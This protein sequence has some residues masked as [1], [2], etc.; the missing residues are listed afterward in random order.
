MNQPI[1]S[2]KKKSYICQ[3][4][5]V[6]ERGSLRFGYVFH[7]ILQRVPA[8]KPFNRCSEFLQQGFMHADKIEVIVKGLE[9]VRFGY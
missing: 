9:S 1:E 5:L 6:H 8:A 3:C 7:L 4:L 2:P